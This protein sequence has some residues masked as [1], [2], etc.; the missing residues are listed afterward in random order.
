MKL[1]EL[2]DDA[3]M[4]KLANAEPTIILEISAKSLIWFCIYLRLPPFSNSTD[5][6]SRWPAFVAVI[7][8]PYPKVFLLTMTLYV[9]VKNKSSMKRIISNIP[10]G[11]T[12]PFCLSLPQN[13][14]D[15]IFVILWIKAYV[16]IK[17]RTHK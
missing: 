8:I 11:F 3:S 5:K 1:V 15:N 2:V 9:N 12:F 16:E 7:C 13:I 4:G 6:M 10:A 14:A 17:N